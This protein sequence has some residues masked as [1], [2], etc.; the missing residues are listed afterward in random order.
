M[1]GVGFI[2]GIVN[3]QLLVEFYVKFNGNYIKTYQFFIR[4]I[5]DLIRFRGN[6]VMV[7]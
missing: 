2:E 1:I 7:G 6:G 4:F 3:I 5:L